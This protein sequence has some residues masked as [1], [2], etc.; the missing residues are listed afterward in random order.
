MAGGVALVLVAVALVVVIVVLRKTGP[1]FCQK[2]AV[3]A[4]IDPT[5]GT[6]AE[7]ELRE[8]TSHP[9]TVAFIVLDPDN[10]PGAAPNGPYRAAIQRAQRAGIAVYG[11][12]DSGYAKRPAADALADVR[13]WVDWYGVRNVFFDQVA[14]SAQSFPYYVPLAERVRAAAA[15]HEGRLP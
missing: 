4:Y 14:S 12:V 11:Y 6:A 1:P 2:V 5:T 3:P 13:R 7:T 8:L 15:R 9:A 10:G